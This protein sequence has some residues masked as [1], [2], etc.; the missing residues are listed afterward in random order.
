MG[1]VGINNV[2]SYRLVANHA[3]LGLSFSQSGR[4]PACMASSLPICSQPPLAPT[5]GFVGSRAEPIRKAEW[6]DAAASSALVSLQRRVPKSWASAEFIIL[7]D[8]KRFV[9]IVSGYAVRWQPICP[10]LMYMGCVG[11]AANVVQPK[12]SMKNCSFRISRSKGRWEST[13]SAKCRRSWK[14]QEN[15]FAGIS[16]FAVP[17]RIMSMFVSLP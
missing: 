4:S 7:G 15:I 13:S 11:I 2:G 17:R 10:A 9:G 16:P 14:E 1:H 3:L 6:G 8:T 12:A 5:H